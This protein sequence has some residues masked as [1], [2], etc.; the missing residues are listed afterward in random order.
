MNECLEIYQKMEK[1][2][3][4]FIKNAKTNPDLWEYLENKRVAFVG[5]ASYLSGQG[6][7]ELIDSYDIV[8][9]VQPEIWDTKDYGSRTDIIQSCMNSSYSPKLVKYLENT[10]AKN[11]P[12]FI[13]CND[14]VAR[15]IPHP[16]SGKWLSVVKEYND[17]LKHYGV[18]F[19]HLE[20]EDGTWERWG[21]YWEVYAKPHIERVDNSL[22][23]YYSGNFNSGYGAINM[24]LSCPVKELAVFGV[25][26]YNFGVVRSME[27]KYNPAYIAAQGTDGTYLGPDKLLH[28]QMSQIMHCK[29]VLEKDPRFKLDPEIKTR[30]HEEELKKRIDKF[31][32]LPKILHTTQ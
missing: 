11:Y 19:A 12:K 20:N 3:S 9:R 5:P 6:K 26:F 23:T 18:P 31:K 1:N 8:I 14:T 7:G 32:T 30:L 4:L 28:D 10:P 13:I 15:E 29:N 16:G 27:D 21:L 22:Y 2:E 25:D 24:V 17:Y